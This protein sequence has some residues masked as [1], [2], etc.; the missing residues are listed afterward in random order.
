MSI[1]EL[2]DSGDLPVGVHSAPLDEVLTRFGAGHPQRIAV[3]ERLKR[4]YQL[5]ASTGHLARF[6][7]FGS[8]ITD[9]PEPND[10]DAVL[11][12]DD[13]FDSGSLHGETAL[14]FDHSAANTHFGAS[15]FWLRQMAA[16]GGEQAMVEYWQ[17]KRGGGRRG[18]VEI[19]EEVK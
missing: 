19:V 14:L 4:V 17:V 13:T 1:P 12:M 7:V 8:F 2:T 16:L 18:I 6:V 11:V 10:V 3:G 9:K 5:A 15:V